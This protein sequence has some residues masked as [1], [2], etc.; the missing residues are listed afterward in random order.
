MIEFETAPTEGALAEQPESGE[1][2]PDEEQE[3]EGEIKEEQPTE[4]G[5]AASE[6][7]AE[8]EEDEAAELETKAK[9]EDGR[10]IK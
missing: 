5:E 9:A 7:P 1:A 6:Q 4:E 10:Q 8:N 3:A 2:P